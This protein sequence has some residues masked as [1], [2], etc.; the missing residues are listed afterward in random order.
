MQE[1]EG[2]TRSNQHK[3]KRSKMQ[4]IYLFLV[5]LIGFGLLGFSVYIGYQVF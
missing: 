3:P 4:K 1:K 5:L 2:Q